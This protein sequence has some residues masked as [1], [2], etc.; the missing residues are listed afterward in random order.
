MQQNNFQGKPYRTLLL[1][2]QGRGFPEVEVTEILRQ[3]LPQLAHIHAQGLVHGGISV[4]TL[5]QDQTSLQPVLVEN[6]GFVAPGY[7][8]P[9]QLQT[10]QMSAAGDIYAL[11]V[12]MLVLLSGQNPETLRNYDGTW[13]W[14]DYCV[15]SDQLAAVLQRSIAL[16][17][18]D[19]YANA[20]E[21]LQRISVTPTIVTPPVANT[22]PSQPSTGLSYQQTYVISPPPVSSPVSP[23]RSRDLPLWAWV[24][25]GAGVTGMIG[26]AGFGV[27]KLLNSEA[28]LQTTASPASAT[29]GNSAVSSPQVATASPTTSPASATP[30][31]SAVS[32]P[33]VPNM[34]P[35]ASSASATPENNIV[36]SPQVPNVSPT[37]SSDSSNQDIA[38]S[39]EA[40][41]QRELLEIQRQRQLLEIQRQRQL[42]EAQRQRE[43]LEVQRQKQLLEAQ[44]QR[45]S[46]SIVSGLSPA[47]VVQ[48]YYSSLNNRQYPAGW[49]HLST[50]FQSNKVVHEKGYQSFVEWW[51]TVERVEMQQVTPV[52]QNT[53]EAVVDADLT[54]VLKKGNVS[55]ESL[56]YFLARD[57]TTGSWRI[58][59][60]QRK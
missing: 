40:Q 14:Q 8:A 19:R 43:L 37:A 44:R 10:G 22:F 50:Q 48:D 55:S 32:S 51:T 38:R 53:Q 3:V 42:L 13:N 41:R 5:W 17:Q 33:Q 1:E 35:T 58:A 56:R 60:V 9:E 15:V 45:R 16:Q 57:A 31:N 25:I 23:Q 49:N 24:I 26:L 54:Y 21:M 7:V 2:R 18:S 46:Q 28:D 39:L 34:S 59:Q 12:T 27:V 11:G 20:M 6:H 4:D 52:F 47:Q 36:S 29:P 30:G